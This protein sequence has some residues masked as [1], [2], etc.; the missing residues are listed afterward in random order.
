MPKKPRQ[1]AKKKKLVLAHSL[2]HLHGH[3]QHYPMAHRVKHVDKRVTGAARIGARFRVN[4]N[5]HHGRRTV[6][7]TH[8]DSHTR[9][10][11]G[12]GSTKKGLKRGSQ[13]TLYTRKVQ[14]REHRQTFP[15][16]G[17]YYHRKHEK[18]DKRGPAPA[19]PA[20]ETRG[21]KRGVGAEE[22]RR[23][24]YSHGGPGPDRGPLKR[25]AGKFQKHEPARRSYRE[26]IRGM[27]RSSDLDANPSKLKYT[28]SGPGPDQ[29]IK[30]H[31]PKE[32]AAYRL[33]VQHGRRRK[34]RVWEES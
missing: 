30:R 11:K 15:P 22:E 16:R 34:A 33:H 9:A 28:H 29:P 26:E 10:E 24:K 17:K 32:S 20:S 27:K 5:A 14:L 19:G 4:P 3:K 6:Y 21:H 1:T 12:K 7:H 2:A 13:E 31:L 25:N 23:K 18:F 8:T